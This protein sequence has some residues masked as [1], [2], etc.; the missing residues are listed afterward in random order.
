MRP[1][2]KS[3]ESGSTYRADDRVGDPVGSLLAAKRDKA[4]ARRF[5]ER[6]G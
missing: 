4:A 1:T 3:R 5:L 2:S 6:A